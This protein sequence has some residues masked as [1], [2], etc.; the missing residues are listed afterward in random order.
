MQLLSH[1]PSLRRR[2]GVW[3]QVLIQTPWKIALWHAQPA[4]LILPRT[5]SSS[6]YHLQCAGS[7]YI[8]HQS[9][10]CTTGLATNQLGGGI[11]LTKVP[12]SKMILTC[13]KLIKP[14]QHNWSDLHSAIHPATATT[15]ANSWFLSSNTKFKE[16]AKS[17]NYY[18]FKCSFCSILGGSLSVTELL[19]QLSVLSNFSQRRRFQ[20]PSQ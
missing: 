17:W 9:A 3:R 15:K 8:N 10:I 5:T 16:Q 2:T 19:L 11:F 1:T 6:L 13:V 18:L 4:F 12:S 14:S 7:S 20:H